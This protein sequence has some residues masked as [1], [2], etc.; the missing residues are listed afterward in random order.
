MYMQQRVNHMDT[1]SLEEQQTR[2]WI[3]KVLAESRQEPELLKEQDTLYSTFIAPFADVVNAVKL[4][5]LDILNALKLNFDMLVTFSPSKQKAAL[6]GYDSRKAEIQKGWDPIEANNKAAFDNHAA[7]LAFMLAPGL[8]LGA[9]LGVAA[10]KTPAGTLNYL[11]DAGIRLPLAGLL[12]GVQ[13]DSMKDTKGASGSTR[14]STASATSKDKG[15][16]ISLVKNTAK[17]MAD[18]F[19]IT[20]YAPAGPLLTEKKT[21]KPGPPWGIEDAEEEKVKP[22][23][24]DEVEKSFESYLDESGLREELEKRSTAF[25]DSKKAHIEEILESAEQQLAIVSA[26]GSATNIEDFGI[27]LEEAQKLGL[28]VQGAETIAADI[29]EAA[30]KLVGEEEFIEQVKEEKNLKP[31]DEI[32]EEELLES[33]SAVVFMEAKKDIQHQ[34]EE[35]L[36]KLQ[37]GV[38]EAIMHDVPV[39]GEKNFKLISST[40][41]GR[42]Y[43]KMVDDAIK[44]VD[45]YKI[46]AQ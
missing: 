41:R 43:L 30:Q 13:Y 14:K 20:H 6:D 17:E 36:P 32:P 10:A 11:D 12:P 21:D 1:Q 19:F 7:P 38:K 33:A 37:D 31:E 42:E 15:G 29:E 46:E 44:Q 3:R 24:K 23:T 45:D 25:I 8:S 2:K 28:E 9:K 18:I 22:M 40:P 26:L 16:L 34:L 39:K 35:G 27:A 5:G 4:T